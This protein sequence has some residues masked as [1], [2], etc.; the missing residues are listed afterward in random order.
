M[1]DMHFHAV[2][3]Q[4][5]ANEVLRENTA[6]HN[7]VRRMTIE[8]EPLVGFKSSPPS[9]KSLPRTNGPIDFIL[10]SLG[11][12]ARGGLCSGLQLC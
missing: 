2:D 1:R 6:R 5:N 10:R 3:A 12:E 4:Q 11:Q 8:K 7:P 9:Q